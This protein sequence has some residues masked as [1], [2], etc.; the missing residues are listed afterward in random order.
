LTAERFVPHLFSQTA[1]A[2]LFRT[3]DIVR[4]L[5]DGNL[6]FVGRTDLRLKV[7]GFRLE[8]GEIEAALATHA[9]VREALVD[10]REDQ[11]GMTRLAAYVVTGGEH[12]PTT[13][14]LHR[15]LKERLPEY[16]L[17]SAFALLDEMPRTPA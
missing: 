11:G 2:R 7:R 9:S 8:P 6:E 16:M 1:G 17:P 3:G 14:E 13:G 12:V 4:Y 10:A 15:H 5:P